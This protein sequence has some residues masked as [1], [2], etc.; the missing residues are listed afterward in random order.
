MH[1]KWC[2]NKLL[3]RAEQRMK[4]VHNLAPRDMETIQ[5]HRETMEAFP[6][7]KMAELELRMQYEETI[8]ELE[9]YIANKG[10]FHE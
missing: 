6:N 8:A 10:P 2:K 1:T 5:D 4:I 7:L 3:P 9:K